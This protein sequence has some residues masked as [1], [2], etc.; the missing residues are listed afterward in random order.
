MSTPAT[1]NKSKELTKS[2]LLARNLVLN[3]I[4]FGAPLIVAVFA[5]PLLPDVKDPLD[6]INNKID[7]SDNKTSEVL[8]SIKKLRKEHFKDLVIIREELENLE[9]RLEVIH[10]MKNSDNFFV[11][12]T[13]VPKSDIIK[14]KSELQERLNERIIIRTSFPEEEDTPPVKL[15][16]PKWLKPFESLTELYALPNYRDL[17]PTFI[18]GPIFLIYAGF[19]LTDFVY[20]LMLLVGGFFVIRKFGKYNPGM[21]MLAINIFW[22]GFFAMLF[23]LLTGSYLGDA[24]KYFFGMTSEQLAIWKD[25]LTDPLYF[26]II[27]LSVAVVHLN[28]GL[29]LGLIE[30]IRKRAWKTAVSERGIWFLLQVSILL[31]YLKVGLIGKLLLGL[32]VL[33]VIIFHGPIGVLG[34]TGFMGDAI[35]YSRLFALALSTAGIALTVN[36]LADLLKGTPYIGFILAGII[37]I[38]GHL[39]S[40]VMNALGSFVHSLRLQFV[41][42]FSKFY[43]GGGDKFEP[44]REERFYTEVKGK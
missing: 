16:N 8:E 6:W 33:L 23:G 38:A 43:E 19:M 15:T 4:G 14:L 5:I 39:F 36:L 25:P 27:S 31:L 34:I 1:I 3:L 42:F 2:N 12:S 22:I 28:V 9:K 32:T 18:V 7:D 44:F 11:L 21:K 37:F 29:V 40:L 13:W 20:G 41:E 35:S 24:P 10:D 26:L 30:D 17:D